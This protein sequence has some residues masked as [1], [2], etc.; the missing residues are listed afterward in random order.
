MV[1]IRIVYLILY[2]TQC[3]A[4]PLSSVQKEA[5]AFISELCDGIIAMH[6]GLSDEEFRNAI[7]LEDMVWQ[8]ELAMYTIR[9]VISLP[10]PNHIFINF[11]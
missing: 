10:S 5:L 2:L 3:I 6:A 4:R 11:T 9:C 1:I 8:M 7:N